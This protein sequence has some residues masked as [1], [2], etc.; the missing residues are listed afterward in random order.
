VNDNKTNI[1][2]VAGN[3]IEIDAVVANSENINAVA[4]NSS[5]INAVAGNSEN[6]NAVV[7]DSDDIGVVATDLGLGVA[8]TIGIVAGSIADV[9][10]V[11]GIDTEVTALAGKTVE[12]DALYAQL[13]TIAEKEN[14]ENKIT[15]WPETPTD[16]EY[17]SAKLVDDRFS[18][19]ENSSAKRFGLRFYTDTG[20]FERIGDAVGLTHRNHA[21]SYTPGVMSD[22]SLYDPW[23]GIKKCKVN[24][25]G[26]I[27]SWFGDGDYE[28]TDGEDMVVFPRCFTGWTPKTIN[29]RPCVDIEVSNVKLNGLYPT[30][31][32]GSDGNIL[33][34]LFV[35]ATKLGESGGS[36]T[37][38]AGIAPKTSKSM[39]SF[40]TDIRAKSATAKWRLNDFAAWH[41]VTTLMII[42]IGT[43]DVKTAIGPGI[44]SGMP[45][46][47]GA[48][49]KCTVSQT[50]ANSIIIAN[51][52]ATNMR[53]GMVMQVGTSYTSNAVAADRAIT[54]I[55]DYDAS[56]K[57]ITLDGAAFDS[58]AGTT[59]IVSWGQPVPADQLDALNGESGYILQFDS[60]TRSHVCW[61]WVWDLWGNVWEWLAGI[62]RVEGKFYISFNRDLHNDFSPVGKAGW[63]DT[64]YTPI[65]ENGYQ[66]EREVITYNDGQIS[67]PKTTGGA[68]VGANTWYAAY[69]YYF[70][71][72]YQSGTR[73]VLVSGGW[74]DG[75]LVSPFYWFGI[76][77]PSDANF[78]ISARAVIEES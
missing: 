34:R 66:K 45:Y 21:G 75:S 9:Q 2:A 61:R 38:R 58:V 78:S 24:S 50:G 19:L 28:T 30:G 67:L 55:E 17:P 1:D 7:A 43:M 68:G 52:G 26:Q 39:T 59:T 31:F 54:L 53:V 41:M 36:L 25:D 6:I 12:I 14:V 4:G 35:G 71:A 10:T 3:E 74:A 63:I 47:S 32:V 5:N 72:S 69:L 62:L 8:S 42:E 11:A 70:G 23:M 33:N 15:S 29:S 13:D 46:G 40:T 51:A 64:G 22:F 73:A 18:V 57:T 20:S 49:F 16:T 77:G 44:Q 56:N 27:L 48:E 37:T 65:V 76:F 60:A